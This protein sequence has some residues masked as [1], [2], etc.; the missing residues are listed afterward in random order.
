VVDA[1][2]AFV[3]PRAPGIPPAAGN[4][5]PD[6]ALNADQDRPNKGERGDLVVEGHVDSPSVRC[7]DNGQRASIQ[8]GRASHGSRSLGAVA[9]GA[10]PRQKSWPAGGPLGPGSSLC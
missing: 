10:Q 5:E 4:E 6:E 1:L 3:P 9:G 2:A 8:I 7:H